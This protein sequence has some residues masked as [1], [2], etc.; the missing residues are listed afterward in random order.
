[1][2]LSGLPRWDKYETFETSKNV[3]VF[4]TWRK[5]FLESKNPFLYLSS[6]NSFLN[7]LC[8]KIPKDIEIKFAWHHEI[9]KNNSMLPKLNSR[10][11]LIRPEE[12]SLN[13]QN[14]NMLVTDYS[15]VFWDYFYLNKPVVFYNPVGSSFENS[16]DK[17]IRNEFLNFGCEIFNVFDDVETAIEKILYYVKNNFVLEEK[18]KL[19]NKKF[20]WIGKNNSQNI[21]KRI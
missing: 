5:A 16:I 7:L 6:I 9:Y 11:K 8:E 2:I 13:I 19:A 10:I 12:F 4:F 21:L 20:F 14:S 17:T 3:F 15:S 18:I 1:M